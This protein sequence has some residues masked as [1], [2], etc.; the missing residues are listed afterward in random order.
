[1]HQELN[2]IRRQLKLLSLYAIIS[3]G[4]FLFIFASSFSGK[5]LPAIIRAKGIIIEDNEGRDRIL[6]GSPAP[7]SKDRLRTDS[8]KVKELWAKKS[9][10]GSDKYM[11]YYRTYSHDANGIIFLNENG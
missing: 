9:S 10:L 4:L 1:M 2:K 6:I 7:H 11:E 8:V 5:D 3:T